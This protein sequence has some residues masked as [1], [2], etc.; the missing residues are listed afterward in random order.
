MD[1]TAVY[2]KV[3]KVRYHLK[4]ATGRFRVEPPGHRVPRTVSVFL[5]DKVTQ[6]TERPLVSGAALTP[7]ARGEAARNPRGN[8]K[9]SQE[10]E[11]KDA[12]RKD[13]SENN[14]LP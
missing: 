13:L 10:R 7:G 5:Q 1:K 4:Y 12:G 8:A 2:T 9:K 14:F 3:K 11:R 6:R